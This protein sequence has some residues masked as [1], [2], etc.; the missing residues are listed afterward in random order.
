MYQGDP[1][2]V[3]IS[4]GI[5]IAFSDL[6]STEGFD[7]SSVEGHSSNNML[8]ETIVVALSVTLKVVLLPVLEDGIAALLNIGCLT[9]VK[10]DWLGAKLSTPLS[11]IQICQ[12]QMTTIKGIQK[13][14]TTTELI[15]V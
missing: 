7:S 11:F 3:F 1:V 15:F 2:Y 4:R 8:L 10:Y 6:C 5:Y 12:K 13:S 14:I 9:M